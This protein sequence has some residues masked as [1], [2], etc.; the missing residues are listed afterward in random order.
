MAFKVVP[1]TK[2]LN[3]LCIL[4]APL[5]LKGRK[6]KFGG[7]HAACGPHF[8]HACYMVII[9]LEEMKYFI[10]IS[11]FYSQMINRSLTR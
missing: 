2:I 11:T 10:K 8:G 7:P 4:K 6:K 9:K 1:F 5:K 3:V